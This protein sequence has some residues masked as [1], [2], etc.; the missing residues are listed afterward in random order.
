VVSLSFGF[1]D[2]NMKQN[3]M[4]FE[5]LTVVILEITVFWIVTLCSFVCRYQRFGDSCYFHLHGFSA[6]TH[7]VSLISILIAC[8][9]SVS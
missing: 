2:Q 7:P 9:F 8:P 3:F 1:P 6:P 5:V 4:R